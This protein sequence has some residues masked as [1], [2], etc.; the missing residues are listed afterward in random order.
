[1]APFLLER[2]DMRSAASLFA[3]AGLLALSSPCF[4]EE[5]D[6]LAPHVGVALGG[7]IGLARNW[8]GGDNPF[9]WGRGAPSGTKGPEVDAGALNPTLHVDL[10]VR[11]NGDFSVYARGEVGTIILA[12]QAAAYGIF[13]W[14]PAPGLHLGTGI[15]WDGM[16]TWQ[17]TG[18][19]AVS[20]PLIAGV[21]VTHW[22]R[23]ALRIGLEVAPGLDPSTSTVGWHAALTF[24]WVLN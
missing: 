24:G 19:S 16:A 11:L 1:M 21:D 2:Q 14:T 17:E 18:W 10:G 15:G 5:G 12:S 6:S 23:S 7:V 4:A 8:P 9:A 20:I 13:E 3:V 22:N